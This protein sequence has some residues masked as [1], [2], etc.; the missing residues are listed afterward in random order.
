MSHLLEVLGAI[1]P[2]HSRQLRVDLDRAEDIVLRFKNP[3][4]RHQNWNRLRCKFARLRDGLPRLFHL[5]LGLIRASQPEPLVGQFRL[6]FVSQSAG[7]LVPLSRQLLRQFG[8]AL[9]QLVDRD[10]FLQFSSEPR[11]ALFIVRGEFLHHAK[12][13]ER[14]LMLL[15][16]REQVDL[17][18]L[19][20][21][22]LR[23]ELAGFGIGLDRFG[24]VSKTGEDF[25]QT[26]QIGGGLRF[27]VGHLPPGRHCLVLPLQRMVILAE[28]FLV[29]SRFRCEGHRLLIQLQ[30]LVGHLDRTKQF[31]DLRR[32]ERI[33]RLG[34]R[35]PTPHGGSVLFAS[36]LIPRGVLEDHTAPVAQRVRVVRLV[37]IELLVLRDRLD[38][39]L[40]VQ[41]LADQRVTQ[42]FLRGRRLQRPLQPL[43]SLRPATQSREQPRQSRDRFQ[44][45]GVLLHPRFVV[46][47][48]SRLIVGA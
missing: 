48:Q 25:G 29:L 22:L 43:L 19:E 16:L 44:V 14:V 39:F 5:P 11:L 13:L 41:Q 7:P 33:F 27:P 38:V 45:L 18:D 4:G 8:R 10:Q 47:N 35:Q 17:L 36:G 26:S 6:G 42:L 21:D 24:E 46:G 2:V 34:C 3:R 40:F 12:L 20:V 31:G 37:L 30:R 23:V 15:R 9:L 32:D 28:V 1:P